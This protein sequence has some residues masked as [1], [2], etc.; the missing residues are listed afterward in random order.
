MELT[1]ALPPAETDSD[2]AFRTPETSARRPRMLVVDDEEGPRLSLKVIFDDD[3]DIELAEDGPSAVELAKERA[4]D[5]AVLDIRMGGMSGIEV[6][7]RL[8][9]VDPAIQAVMMTAFETTDTIRQALRLEA[10]DYLNKPFDVATMR[11]AV[12]R[13][14]ER[15]SLAS[16]VRTNAEQL[17]QLQKELHDTRMDREAHRERNEIYGSIIHDINGPLTVISGHLQFI[18]ERVGDGRALEGE[19]LDS[20]KDRLRRITRQA[21]NCIGI[22]RRYL[23]FLRRRPS[24]APAV[25]ANQMLADVRDL[26]QAHPSLGSHQFL[27]HPLPEDVSVLVHGTDLIQ[28]LQNL[29]VNALQC[30]PQFHRVEIHGHLLN[31]PLDLKLFADGREDRFINRDL[32]NNT[33]PLLSLAV[34]DNGPGI[35][36]EVLPLLFEPYFTTKPRLQGTG[37]GLCIVKRLLAEA[38][39]GLHVH[40]K[41]GQ[42]TVFTVY[43]P[44]IPPEASADI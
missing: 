35:P 22:S 19:D 38:R 27:V 39:G 2:F 6:L 18:N 3:F 16:E 34:Q 36:P 4:F 44:A 23:N 5:V 32:F 15:R 11:A 28:I 8:R 14:M 31:Q 7:E 13:A 26:L 24:E 43:L 29:T 1:S 41:V 21:T 9:F 20:V 17:N 40:T 37:L 10:C 42:G 30:S 12:Q 25:W 33:S